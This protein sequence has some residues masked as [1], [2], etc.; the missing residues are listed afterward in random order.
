M[1]LKNDATELIKDRFNLNEGTIMEMIECNVINQEACRNLLIKQEY[2]QLIVV[3]PKDEAKDE[4][5]EKHCI[6][7]SMVEKIVLGFTKF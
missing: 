2:Q 7:F 6:S 3:M 4:L 1:S 5:A